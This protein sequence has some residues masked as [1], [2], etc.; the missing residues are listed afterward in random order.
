M[1]HFMVCL[2]DFSQIYECILRFNC[3][4]TYQHFN[5]F[6]IHTYITSIFLLSTFM[7]IMLLISMYLFTVFAVQ[8][9]MV[10]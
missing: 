3:I 5:E 4:A 1:F 6:Y 7:F 2:I 10:Q 9:F 8:W